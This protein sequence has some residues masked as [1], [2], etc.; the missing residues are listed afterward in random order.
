M[1]ENENTEKVIPFERKM[2]SRDEIMQDV[3]TDIC[4]VEDDDPKVSKDIMYEILLDIRELVGLLEKQLAS[5][6]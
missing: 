3:I 4:E 5:S 2:R 6:E 1:Q